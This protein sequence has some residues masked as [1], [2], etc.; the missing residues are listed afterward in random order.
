[1]YTVRE[2]TPEDWPGIWHIFHDVVRRGDTYAFAPDTDEAEAKRVWMDAPRATFVTVEGDD[3][4]RD[5]IGTY[6]LKTNQVGTGAHVCNAGYMVRKDQRGRGLGRAMCAH[7]LDVA[8]DLGYHA[9]QFNFVAAT[10][11]GAIK[12]WQDCEFEIVG[13]LPQ[14][15]NHAEDGYVDALVM[16]RLL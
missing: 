16:Y 2:A 15:F 14:A 12:L 6:F 1:M 4:S 8:R 7:S 3:S 5:V 10:N 11:T 13:R 9:M